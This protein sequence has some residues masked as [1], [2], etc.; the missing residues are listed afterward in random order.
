MVLL[1]GFNL[2][3][4]CVHPFRDGNG[5]VSRLLMLLQAYHGNL[6][7]G[8]YISLE[9]LIEENKERYYETL[10]Q[11][12][13][14]WQEGEHDPWPYIQFILYVFKLAYKEFEDRLGRME[15]PRGEKRALVEEF[16]KNAGDTFSVQDVKN[17]CPGVSIDMIRRVLK[18]LRK[19]SRVEC[20]G[21]GQAAR[22]R[23]IERN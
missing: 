8:R 16:I 6:E 20:L 17:H 1:A 18:D 23:K 13:R 4:L 12:S 2:D 5:R 3:F 15:S 22:W 9:R 11:S 14:R 19:L 7:V 10:E 21:M